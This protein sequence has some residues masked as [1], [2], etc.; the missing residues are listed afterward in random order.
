M[1]AR[2]ARASRTSRIGLRARPTRAPEGGYI[3]LD[4]W[5]EPGGSSRRH[6]PVPASGRAA[7]P[8]LA[9]NPRLSRWREA[10]TNFR[11]PF[12]TYLRVVRHAIKLADDGHLRFEL[13]NGKIRL[14]GDDAPIVLGPLP[15]RQTA[16][17]AEDGNPRT[18]GSRPEEPE[19]A[20]GADKWSLR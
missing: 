4:N 11:I 2:L 12:A 20:T 6:P 8:A 13:R 10:L 3:S 5:H 18:A 19:V 9:G 7:N 16:T 1:G 14:L 17:P 15:S